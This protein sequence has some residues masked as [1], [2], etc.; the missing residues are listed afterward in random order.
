MQ[1]KLLVVFEWGVRIFMA[2]LVVQ[3]YLAGTAVFN[4][5]SYQPHRMLGFVLTIL[6]ILLP[7]LALAG[8][9]GRKVV[10]MALLLVALVIVQALL[11][12]LRGPAPWIAALHPANALVLMGVSMRLQRSG[13]VV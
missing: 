11:P 7:V 4:A 13:L 6:A 5:L 12:A 8:R 10:G 9:M 2:G 1:K 3:F